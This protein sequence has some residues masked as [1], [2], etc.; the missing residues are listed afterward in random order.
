MET[1]V[2][3]EDSFLALRC[4]GADIFSSRKLFFLMFHTSYGS[5]S[6]LNIGEFTL[7]RWIDGEKKHVTLSRHQT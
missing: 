7:L 3:M 2:D 6:H 4:T 1:W 5:D